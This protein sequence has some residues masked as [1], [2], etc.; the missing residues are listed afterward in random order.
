MHD[1]ARWIRKP[2]SIAAPVGAWVGERDQLIRDIQLG[3]HNPAIYRSQ[4][5]ATVGIG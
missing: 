5:S 3:R 2:P 4:D 1:E